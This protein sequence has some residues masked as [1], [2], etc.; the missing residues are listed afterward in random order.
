VTVRG[1]IVTEIPAKTLRGVYVSAMSRD[2]LRRGYGGASYGGGVQDDLGNFEIHGVPPGSY[3]LSAGLNDGIHFY[4]GRALVD[5]GNTNVDGLAVVV[6]SGGALR[7]RLRL[8][9]GAEMDITRLNVYLQPAENY[10]GGASA[11]V[12]V[13]GTFV[14]ENVFEGTYHVNVVG[15]PEEFYLQ[16]ARLGGADVLGPG[17][18]ISHND[19]QGNLEVVLSKDGG[20]VD[21][22]VLKNQGPAGGAL[23]VLIPDPPNRGRDDLYD[24]K[25]TD[26]LGRFS[27]LG[28]PPGDFKLFA[29]EQREGLSFTDPDFLKDYEDRGLRVHIEDKKQQ[30]I[31]LQVIPAPDDQP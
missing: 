24:S 16:S 25:T 13:D 23:V 5:V 7:G 22:V 28:L 19:P 1:R 27:L 29:W 4:S 12:K 8:S 3:V 2:S 21:G 31:Q 18:T 14:L 10:G 17:L 26:P 15:F 11:Q 6:G 30:S 9:P 20:R